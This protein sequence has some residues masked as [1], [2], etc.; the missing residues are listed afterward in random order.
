[1]DF[2]IF[3]VAKIT[4]KIKMKIFPEILSEEK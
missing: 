3:Q 1:V 2:N 4:N